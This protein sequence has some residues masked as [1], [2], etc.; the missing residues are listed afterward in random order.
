MSVLKNLVNAK[1]TLN[2]LAKSSDM[3]VELSDTELKKIQDILFE[4]YHDLLEVCTKYNIKLYFTGGSA[5]G[6]V[7]HKGYIPWDED[8]DLAITR[9][10]F[11]KLTEVFEKELSDKYILNAPNYSKNAKARSPMIL[12]KDSYFETVIDVHDENLHKLYVDLFVIENVPD[13]RIHRFFKGSMSNMLQFISS[14]VYFYECRDEEMKKYMAPA[15]WSYYHFRI[16]IGWLFSFLSA[17]KWFDLTDKMM[18]YK[19]ENSKC[20]GTVSGRRHYFK[21]V[22]PRDIWFPSKIKQFNGEDVNVFNK[23]EEYLSN[24]YGD[25]M[26]IPPV[27]KRERHFVYKIKL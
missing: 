2:T 7:R 15:G 10:D 22:L 20:C 26:K 5:L 12:K 1:S 11:N 9:K 6:V 25:Y 27:E 8:L 16:A 21:E 23:V 14:Q 24:L 4:M 13:N 19:N 18:Q 17:S 3:L